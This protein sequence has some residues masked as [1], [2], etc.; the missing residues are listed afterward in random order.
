MKLMSHESAIRLGFF[1]GVLVL[2]AVWE[3][4][5][6]RR[7]LSTAKPFRWFSNLGL[8]ALNTLAVRLLVPLGAV[9]VAV[10]AEEHGWGLF[11]NVVVPGWLAVAL[12]V[13]ALDLAIYL[14]HV[15]FHA[16]PLLW[17]LHMIHHADLDFDVTTGV[18]FHTIEI[19]LS[20]GIK[21]G[22]VILLGAS[23]LAVV[24]FEVVLNATSMF[25]H[26]NVRLPRWLDRILR[27]IVVTPE[28]HRVHHSVLP[29]ETNSN[30][31]FNLPWWD[32]LFGTY[33]D[34]PAA[35]HEAMTIGLTQLRDEKRTGRLHWML[36]LP[37]IGDAGNYPIN[38]CGKPKETQPPV[39]PKVLAAEG[40]KRQMVAAH[41]PE[42]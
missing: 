6:P 38:Q 2:M 9:G 25:N 3:M 10:A 11:H 41:E 16:V 1:A 17:R 5:A 21:M 24:V 42:T 8:V 26:G 15:M 18:R 28:M 39:E 23:A 35:G 14:Q 34:Q 29:R 4:L 36:A 33:R 40:K 32:F 27:L 20:L 13:V 37:F 7:R 22:A 19:L 30:F 31:G 12:S